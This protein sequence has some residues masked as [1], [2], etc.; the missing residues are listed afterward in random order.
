MAAGG[1]SVSRLRQGRIRRKIFNGFSKTDFSNLQ[2]E[3]DD[4]FVLGDD[5]ADRPALPFH[6]AHRPLPTDRRSSSWRRVR[7]STVAASDWRARTMASACRFTS[8][9]S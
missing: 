9:Y 2:V 7:S 1:S 5:H 4:G 8:A 3:P 6:A